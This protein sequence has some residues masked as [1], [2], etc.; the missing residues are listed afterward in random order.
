MESRGNIIVYFAI[1]NYICWLLS[2]TAIE[3]YLTMTNFASEN[4]D[5][6]PLGFERHIPCEKL[7]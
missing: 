4:G 2:F 1:E 3:V 6:G 7:Y 5:V